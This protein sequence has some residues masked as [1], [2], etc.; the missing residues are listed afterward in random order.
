MVQANDVPLH[1][2]FSKDRRCARMPT[3]NGCQTQD[4]QD[5]DLPKQLFVFRQVHL[6]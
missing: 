1:R 4:N 3:F 6:R 5:W 2:Y